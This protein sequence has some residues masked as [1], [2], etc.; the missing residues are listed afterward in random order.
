M[1]IAD[2]LLLH[3]PTGL[4]TIF[5]SKN[6]EIAKLY[7]VGKRRST[8]FEALRFWKGRSGLHKRW[9]QCRCPVDQPIQLGPDRTFDSFD[10]SKSMKRLI[11]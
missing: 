6:P 11:L 4:F 2:I 3:C 7:V 9:L 5:E 1:Y 8:D 10:D